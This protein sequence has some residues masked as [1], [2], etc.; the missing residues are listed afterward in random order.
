MA[1]RESGKCQRCG[2]LASERWPLGKLDYDY[3]YGVEHRGA[4]VKLCAS[5]LRQLADWLARVDDGR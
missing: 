4:T 1:E 3:D 5:C 2:T